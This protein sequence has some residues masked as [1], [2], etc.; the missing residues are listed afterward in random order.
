QARVAGREH[1]LARQRHAAQ[2]AHANDVGDAVAAEEPLGEP[3]PVGRRHQLGVPNE[4]LHGRIEEAT[5]E[6][7]AS[8]E[9]LG[10]TGGHWLLPPPPPRARV[11]TSRRATT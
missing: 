1:G 3:A 6:I 9:D 7:A 2:L 5:L 11:C 4:E 8:H 10:L